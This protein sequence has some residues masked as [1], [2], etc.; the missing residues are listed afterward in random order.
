MVFSRKLRY[1]FRSLIHE[2]VTCHIELLALSYK[3]RMGGRKKEVVLLECSMFSASKKL[4]TKKILM[5]RNKEGRTRTYH[6]R[7]LR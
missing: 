1:Y 5:L 3:K 4:K 6:A 7:F 2:K